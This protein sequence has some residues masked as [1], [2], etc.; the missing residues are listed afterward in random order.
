MEISG[1]TKQER[2][3]PMTMQQNMHSPSP[4]AAKMELGPEEESILWC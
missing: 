1:I 3:E 4:N 2:L